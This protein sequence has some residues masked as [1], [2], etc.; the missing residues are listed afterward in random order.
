[1]SPLYFRI[2]IICVTVQV[3]LSEINVLEK[4]LYGIFLKKTD[5]LVKVAVI[6]VSF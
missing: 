3:D 5:G 1:M 6:A 4:C 2:V